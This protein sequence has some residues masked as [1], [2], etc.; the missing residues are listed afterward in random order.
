MNFLLDLQH[1]NASHNSCLHNACPACCTAGCNVN[2][3][4]AFSRTFGDPESQLDTQI[5]FFHIVQLDI[6]LNIHFCFS[7]MVLKVKVR[8][9]VRTSI[10]FSCHKTYWIRFHFQQINNVLM[11]WNLYTKYIVRS[12]FCPALVLVHCFLVMPKIHVVGASI[13]EFQGLMRC[14]LNQPHTTNCPKKHLPNDAMGN[15]RQN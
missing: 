10:T 4:V 3:S 1:K 6:Y 7:D 2:L 14:L 9:L 12:K 8:P 15:K 11:F 13:W 5:I